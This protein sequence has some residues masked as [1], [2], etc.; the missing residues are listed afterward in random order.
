[1]RKLANISVVVAALLAAAAATDRLAAWAEPLTLH[2]R[3]RTPDKI[4]GGEG[5]AVVVE[6]TLEWEPRQTALVI[7]DMWDQHW[8]KGAAER[9]EELA[10]PVNA[11]VH[12]AR[13]L[14]M[15]IIHAPSTCVDF[16][17]DTP[18][19]ALARSAPFA[20][21]PLPLSEAMRWGTHWCWPD[22]AHEPAL[23][24]DDSDMGCDCATNARFA[25][26]GRASTP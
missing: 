10:G 23:P 12:R 3:S 9:V 21:P 16:Y 25:L 7:C 22:P 11:V 1:M 13:D 19:R 26:P 14:G 20:K 18:Q 17:K 2:A 15:L 24:I 5:R 4:P 6:K 8:C